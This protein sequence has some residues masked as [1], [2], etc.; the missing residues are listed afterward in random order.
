MSPPGRLEPIRRGGDP[1][2]SLAN[3][4]VSPLQHETLKPETLNAALLTTVPLLCYNIH[5]IR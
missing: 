5:M 2:P 3:L 1:S 4:P